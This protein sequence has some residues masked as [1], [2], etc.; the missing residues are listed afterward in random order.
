MQQQASSLMYQFEYS[1]D[2]FMYLFES[3]E[4]ASVN[5]KNRFGNKALHLSLNPE[6]DKM[7]SFIIHSLITFLFSS[8]WLVNVLR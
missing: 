4:G 7:V 8:K 6:I 2:L 3:Q 1:G 5:I